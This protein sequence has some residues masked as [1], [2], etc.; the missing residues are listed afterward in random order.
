MK[1]VVIGFLGTKLDMGRKRRWRPT[2]GLATNGQFHIDRLEIL[3]DRE[4]DRLAHRVRS[5]VEA[6]SPGTEVLLRDFDLADPWDF[7]EVYGKLFD[8]ARAYG[9]DEDR[10]RYH[11]HLTT[12][13]HVAQ[14]CWFLLTESRHI[15]ARLI[16][17]GP[18]G[19]GESAPRLDIIDLDLSRY[20]ALQ[21]R[22]DQLSRAYSDQLKGGIETRNA[23][24]NALIDRIELVAS[25]SD[26]PILLLGET[27]TGK[28]ELAERI[29]ALKLDR[30]RVKG[31]MVHVNCAT[32]RG[33][34][35]MAALFGQRRGHTGV[36]G[37]ERN[38]L[39]READG[40]VLFLDEVDELGLGEQAVLLHAI[41]S[42]RF[43]PLGSDHE[44][45]SRFRILSGASRDLRALGAAGAFRP[46]LLA[47]LGMWS[48]RLPPMRERREDIEPNLAFELARAERQLGTR[49]GFNTDARARYLTFASDPATAWP[50]NFRDFGASVRRLCTLAPRGRI[51]RSMVE[52]EI[53]TLVTDW[54]TATSDAD[55]RLVRDLL[56]EAAGDVD[57]FDVVQL[58]H[59]LRICRQ[60]P[61][62][63]AAGRS[64]FAASR[65]RKS[66][67]ND[68]DRLRKYLARFGLAWG[69]L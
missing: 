29:H 12:G 56:G 32:L 43:Y 35:A 45:S 24:Y 1:N 6:A 13:T 68:A 37:S 31:R 7:Q 10:E 4:Y 57:P 22:F 30:R 2:P 8:F 38:G 16:Q 62:L 33:P 36:A 39:L 51:T 58:A 40:G 49:V 23:A 9:F 46:D 63:S 28:T 67:Q 66:T 54:G 15:P 41:E 42:G 47:R 65:S 55:Q 20:N 48:F 52:E 50:G 44:V 69:A 26:E 18:P 11:V 19:P 21:Q 3:F 34:D 64:L 25:A 5:E 53:A 59:V 27:G 14:I 60:S 17:T 61:S